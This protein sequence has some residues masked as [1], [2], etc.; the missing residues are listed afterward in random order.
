MTVTA[1]GIVM[2]P[3]IAITV[4]VT[5]TVITAAAIAMAT[6]ILSVKE[7]SVFVLTKLTI[8]IILMPPEIRLVTRPRI[9]VTIAHLAAL[10]LTPI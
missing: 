2:L 3:T 8:S 10:L 4:E 1:I 6:V 5:I 7:E 9:V